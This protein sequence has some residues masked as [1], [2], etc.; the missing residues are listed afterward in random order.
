MSATRTRP[1]IGPVQI[2]VIILALAA[3]S[4]HL[5]IWFIEGI[6]SGL[7]PE[8]QM[9]AIYQVLFVGNFLGYVTLLCALYLPISSL[10]RFRPV[11]RTIIIS[12]AFASVASYFHVGAYD[13]LGHIT[14]VIE[15]LLIMLLTVD[16][17]MSNPREELAGR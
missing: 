1:S 13:T 12:I 15:V 5:Y 6:F 4:V 17:G 14:K 10:A 7:A 3:A 2:G 16:A 9:G 11:V 8:Q